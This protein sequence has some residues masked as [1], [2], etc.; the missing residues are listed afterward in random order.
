[1]VMSFGYLENVDKEVNGE[2]LA[3]EFDNKNLDVF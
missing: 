2:Q 1:M 3:S